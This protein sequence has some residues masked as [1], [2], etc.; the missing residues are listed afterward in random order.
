MTRWFPIAPG[1]T[2]PT[3]PAPVGGQIT[4]TRTVPVWNETVLL[5]A[6]SK[7]QLVVTN[8]DYKLS[9]LT[10]TDPVL[11]RTGVDIKKLT[12]VNIS[13]THI[14]VTPFN[15]VIS[16][17]ARVAIPTTAAALQYLEPVVSS[18]ASILT[19]L[20][21]CAIEVHVPEYTGRLR[22]IID[23]PI[24][25]IALTSFAPV[26]S[27]GALVSPTVVNV[28]MAAV[29][30]AIVKPAPAF[31]AAGTVAATDYSSTTINWPTHQA[32]DIGILLI[33]SLGNETKTTP[34]GWNAFPSTPVVNR[35]TAA[36]RKLHAWWRRAAGSSETGVSTSPLSTTV[37]VIVTVRGCVTSGD[38]YDVSAVKSN[39]SFTTTPTMPSVTTTVGNT[40]IFLVS[41]RETDDSSTT[42]YSGVTNANLTSLAEQLEGGSNLANGGGF[43][44]C[45]GIKANAGSTGTTSITRA[46]GGED[47]ALTVAFKAT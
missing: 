38:P 4:A 19:A 34:S 41:A 5:A 12:I 15:P 3:A 32:N 2:V 23:T 8:F 27:K 28:S 44:V 9:L 39:T 36:G 42:F 29:S 47:V 21:D 37:G 13:T 33:V 18:G 31:Q 17:G 35:T 40:L 26:I 46:T 25:D 10:E 7:T 16:T 11:T 43:V 14:E 6:R 24:G 1:T 45:T 30:P 22:T 20:S